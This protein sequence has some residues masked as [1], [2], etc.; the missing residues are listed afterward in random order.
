MA[1]LTRWRIALTLTETLTISLTAVACGSN[2][3]STGGASTGGSSAN[4]TGASAG[5]SSGA[6]SSGGS[7]GTGA[8]GMT[9]T[10]ASTGSSSGAA[11]SGSNSSTGA[12]GSSVSSGASGASGSGDAGSCGGNFESALVKTCASPTD[13]SLVRHSDCCGTV[14]MAIRNGTT[15][16][17]TA[18]EMA[19]Q[20]CVPGCGLR[21]CNHPETA[22]DGKVPTGAEQA[23]VALCQNIRCTSAVR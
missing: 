2:G 11:S 10:G 22:E 13:C 6:A 8:S 16:T 9:S 3:T 21:G 19:Y 4:S 17:F 7:S 12:S 18:A 5:S 15:A 1:S 14:V 23:I 20:S